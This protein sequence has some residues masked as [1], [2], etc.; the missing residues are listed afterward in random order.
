MSE[1]K[2]FQGNPN[3]RAAVLFFLGSISFIIGLCIVKI[4]GAPLRG[5]GAG[6]L[7]I[8]AGIFMLVIAALRAFYKRA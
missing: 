2:K 5:T 4:H 1:Q 6:T 7:L 3:K 8:I